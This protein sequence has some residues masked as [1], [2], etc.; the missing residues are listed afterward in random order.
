MSGIITLAFGSGPALSLTKNLLSI[1]SNEENGDDGIFFASKPSKYAR[2][3]VVSESLPLNP[4][5]N[6][7]SYKTVQ[8]DDIQAIWAEKIHALADSE[9]Q[10]ENKLSEK[11]WHPLR[12]WVKRDKELYSD[13]FRYY[14]ESCDTFG[15]IHCFMEDSENVVAHDF[16]TTIADE[17]IGSSGLR[18]KCLVWAFTSSNNESVPSDSALNLAKTAPIVSS[19]IPLLYSAEQS[20][21]ATAINT[22]TRYH[23]RSAVSGGMSMAQNL[24][25]ILNIQGG[26]SVSRLTGFPQ[27][28]RMGIQEL[29][30]E[31]YL[32]KVTAVSFR[33]AKQAKSY[34]EETVKVS[35]NSLEVRILVSPTQNSSELRGS[36]AIDQAS[37]GYIESTRRSLET[38]VTLDY[39]RRMGIE[40]DETEEMVE[41]LHASLAQ[42][43]D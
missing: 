22:V 28:R 15:G 4:T 37:F 5:T 13:N 27:T 11:Y 43:D 12:T 14:L 7:T 6:R 8:H 42:R 3:L 21:V 33:D 40:Q 23:R 10:T 41:M 20:E 25:P 2:A 30:I 17:N 32:G 18:N 26:L 38:R 39:C 1:A 35:S 24:R 31:A 29:G 36:L 19:F 16:L 9:T 34:Q